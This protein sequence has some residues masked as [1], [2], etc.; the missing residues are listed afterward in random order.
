MPFAAA[1]L[2]N[3][4]IFLATKKQKL[5]LHIAFERQGFTFPPV[6]AARHAIVVGGL[7][8]SFRDHDAAADERISLTK[9]RLRFFY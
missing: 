6:K 9:I 3:E 4:S 2:L 8:L 5:S 7:P 1:F